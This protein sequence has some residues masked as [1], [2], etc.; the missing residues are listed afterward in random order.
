M[1]AFLESFMPWGKTGDECGEGSLG[2]NLP[3]KLKH[4]DWNLSSTT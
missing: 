2:R 4:L 1:P 3:Q